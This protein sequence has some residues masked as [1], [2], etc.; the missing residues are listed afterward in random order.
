MYNTPESMLIVQPGRLLTHQTRCHGEF[1]SLRHKRKHLDF[2][3]LTRRT[4]SE[5]R[6][7]K[8]TVSSCHSSLFHT[9]AVKLHK[10]QRLMGLLMAEPMPLV[11]FVIHGVAQLRPTTRVHKSS[12]DPVSVAIDALPVA[13]GQ[14]IASDGLQGPPDVDDID[15]VVFQEVFALGGIGDNI[16]KLFESAGRSEV[17]MHAVCWATIVLAFGW[18]R[19]VLAT[20][21]A[22]EDINSAG[23]EPGKKDDG[24]LSS[25]C[26]TTPAETYCFITKFFVAGKRTSV[27]SSSV[28]H[29]RNA[30]TS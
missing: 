30:G 12:G 2:H 26:T 8:S 18:I 20:D 16:L 27:I 3:A 23:A 9:L 17:R 25:H 15:A 14:R 28:L 5:I 1:S 6:I 10:H 11:L 29:S 24:Q 13:D 19:G 4:L 7:H 22:C 21:T